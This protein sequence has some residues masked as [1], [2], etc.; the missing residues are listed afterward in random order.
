MVRRFDKCSKA[1]CHR[2]L[3]NCFKP[4]MSKV[5]PNERNVTLEQCCG[6]CSDKECS[7][8]CGESRVEDE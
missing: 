5:F 4:D 2:K 3:S 8:K 6:L 7:V 1:F